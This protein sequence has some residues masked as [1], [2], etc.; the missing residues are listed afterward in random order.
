MRGASPGATI[1]GRPCALL[2]VSVIAAAALAGCGSGSGSTPDLSG[3]KG[4]S[5]EVSK[6]TWHDGPWPFKV[7]RGIL[8]CTQPPFPGAVTF[9]VNG[10]LYA[11]NGTA[12]DAHVGRDVMPIWKKAPGG[13]RVDIGGMIDKGLNLCPQQTSQSQAATTTP[14]KFTPPPSNECSQITVST[15]TSCPFARAVVRAYDSAPASTITAYSPGD[16]AD[17]HDALHA[18]RCIRRMRRW[19]QC[20]SGFRASPWR[21]PSD[22]EHELSG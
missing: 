2:V 11:I 10:T 18:C 9:N 17:V 6:A 4:S 1:I 20:V 22:G 14:A 19:P 21:R 5:I 15:H 16:A 12:E 13:L 8:G 7:P 3:I